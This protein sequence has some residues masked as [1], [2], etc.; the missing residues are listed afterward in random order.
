MIE[1]FMFILITYM[2]FPSMGLPRISYDAANMYIKPFL[3]RPKIEVIIE[4][5]PVIEEPKVIA[6]DLGIISVPSA[7]INVGLYSDG[8]AYNAKNKASVQYY[9]S[10]GI[11]WIADHVHQDNFNNLKNVNVGDCVY[12]NDTCYIVC[13]NV[14][15]DNFYT[16]FSGCGFLAKLGDYYTNGGIAIQTCEQNGARI[17]YCTK[18]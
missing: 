18:N 6:G 14:Y 11:C 9:E 5:T 15:Y 13:E 7:K 8:S 2:H 3:E 17:V 1:M 16:D 4:D 10:Y 12:I